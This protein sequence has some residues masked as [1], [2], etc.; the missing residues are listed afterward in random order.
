[1][2]GGVTER[3][4]KGRDQGKGNRMERG[5]EGR[6]EFGMEE[7]KGRKGVGG[8]AGTAPG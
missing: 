4:E 7:L 1:M 3:W 6:E 2:E 5:R 8:V